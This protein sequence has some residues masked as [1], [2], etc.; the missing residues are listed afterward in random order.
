MEI[1]V[2]SCK[3]DGRVSRRWPARISRREGSLIVLDA[4]F[5]EEIRHP[6]IGTIEAG[7][8]STEFFWTDRWYSVFRFQNP[9]GLLLKFYCNI[10]TPARLADGVLSFIDLDV[11][12]LVEPDYSFRVLDE[13]EFDLHSKLYGYPQT[14][15]ENVRR[16]LD[17]L[18]RLIDARHFPFSIN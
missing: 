2:H 10:N 1:S 14:Y 4:V 7:T 18:F 16:A 15:G 13:D 6:L 5:A 17:E 11:D 8:H 12:V 3:H 9:S